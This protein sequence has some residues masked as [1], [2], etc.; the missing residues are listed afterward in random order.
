MFPLFATRETNSEVVRDGLQHLVGH[1]IAVWVDTLDTGIVI[2]FIQ[3]QEESEQVNEFYKHLAKYR[4]INFYK[5]DSR[6]AIGAA[7]NR[8]DWVFDVRLLTVSD[9]PPDYR[10]ED[11]SDDE[12]PETKAPEPEPEPEAEP[13]TNVPETKM[14][15]KK[16]FIQ[17]IAG[18]FGFS[19]EKY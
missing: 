15:P 13:E 3:F 17:R 19:V 12:E 2:R 9:L 5:D 8:D 11:E 10:F 16:Q 14:K 1:G 18:I 4:K 6:W 7:D